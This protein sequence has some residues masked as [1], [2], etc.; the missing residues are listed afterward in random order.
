[1]AQFIKQH[2]VAG[3]HYSRGY[4]KDHRGAD[5]MSND[6]DRTLFHNARSDV[7]KMATEQT[8]GVLSRNFIWGEAKLESG[9]T[10]FPMKSYR[11]FMSFQWTCGFTQLLFFFQVQPT[12]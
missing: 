9:N 10:P 3:L 8:H 4:S 11:D 5:C 6:G 1:V 7:G 2:V 12:Y